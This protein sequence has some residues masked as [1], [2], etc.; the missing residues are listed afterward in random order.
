[1]GKIVRGYWD[2]DYCDTI[3]IAGNI[4][5]CPNCGKTRGKDVVFHVTP[6]DGNKPRHVVSPNSDEYR[7]AKA[8]PDW[9]CSYC[10]SNNPANKTICH[11]CG[12]SKDKSEKHYFELHPERV[13]TIDTTIDTT[14][15]CAAGQTS[16]NS[17][18]SN[19]HNATDNDGDNNDDT[20]WNGFSDTISNLPWRGIGILAAIILAIICI[21]MVLIPKE[22]T[23]TVTDMDWERNIVIE[24]YRT[25]SES[26]WYVP[27]GGRVT[28]TQNEIHHYE[29]VLDHYEK[30]PHERT[31]VTGSHEEVVGYRD[32]GNGYFEKETRTVYDYGTETYYTDEPVYRDEPVYQTKYYYDIER[33]VYDHTETASAH[34]REPYWPE[35]NLTSDKKREGA[36]TASYGLSAIYED[37]ES[38]YTLDYEDWRYISIGDQLHV[39]V[40]ITGRI[41]LID[42]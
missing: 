20:Y 37:K 35:I 26:D 36:H 39:K 41:E 42:E 34:N 3:D 10:D 14:R 2:C 15:H 27:S 18:Y 28:Y 21:V 22:R 30:V 23:I 31:V 33:W 6:H 11:N 5:T 24:E 8:G 9:T 7:Q 32:L 16:R 29:Q 12:H 17:R 40:H 4:Y 1:M 19:A 25:V 38:H 13:A